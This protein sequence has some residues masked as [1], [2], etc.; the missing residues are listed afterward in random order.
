VQGEGP[1]HAH[2]E[3]HL[4]HRERLADATAVPSDHDALEDLDPGPGP[5]DD[6]DVHLDG[7]ARPERRDVGAEGGRV[8][9]VELVH[10]EFAFSGAT[11][12]HGFFA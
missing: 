2:A 12:H 10:G 4:A 6:L 3:R 7:V 8:E 5:L 11:G 1:L 9:G